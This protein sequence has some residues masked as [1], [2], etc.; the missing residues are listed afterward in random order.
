MCDGVDVIGGEE[1][2]VR[3]PHRGLIA[4]GGQLH[5]LRVAEIRPAS[6]DRAEVVVR[7]R[8]Q[9]VDELGRQGLIG[10]EAAQH[11]VHEGNTARVPPG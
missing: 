9:P 4:T 6:E 11:V 8:D 1:A 2:T 7:D 10:G 3:K 5:R